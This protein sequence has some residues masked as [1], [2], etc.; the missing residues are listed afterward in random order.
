[1]TKSDVMRVDRN[2]SAYA[3]EIQMK[4]AQREHKV[5]S[6]T[7]VTGRIATESVHPY[8]EAKKGFRKMG[9]WKL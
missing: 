2:F 7:E 1:M 8:E 6:L 9:E 3:K 5:L 4:I